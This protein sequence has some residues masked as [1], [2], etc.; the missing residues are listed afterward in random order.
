MLRQPLRAVEEDRLEQSLLRR[1][2]P[3]DRARSN[4]SA[5][6]YLINR[7]LQA[8]GGEDGV[9]HLQHPLP[10]APGISPQRPAGA[11]VDGLT[12]GGHTIHG[13]G[14]FLRHS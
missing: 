6:G 14:W 13:R 7:D 5:P 11:A 9:R 12:I 2:M 1:E 10:I 3:A 8:L 4:P